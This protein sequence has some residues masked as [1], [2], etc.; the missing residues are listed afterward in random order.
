MTVLYEPRSVKSKWNTVLVGEVIK[1]P[2][3]LIGRGVEMAGVD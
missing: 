3:Q 2:P 1:E